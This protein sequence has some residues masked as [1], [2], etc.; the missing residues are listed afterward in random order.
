[1][2]STDNVTYLTSEEYQDIINSEAE[3]KDI[4]YKPPSFPLP[5]AET[6]MCLFGN[7]PIY[8][9]IFGGHTEVNGLYTYLND[10]WSFSLYS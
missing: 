3:N 1:M 10:M 4:D 9:V 6:S 7:P 8:L 2:L 5:R